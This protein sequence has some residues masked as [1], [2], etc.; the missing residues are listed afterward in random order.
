MVRF[1]EIPRSARVANAIGFAL[2]FGA[3]GCSTRTQIADS[4]R[5]ADSSSMSKSAV[6]EPAAAAAQTRNR[7]CGDRLITAQGIG[8]LKLG[9]IVD[10]VKRVCQVAYDTVRPGIEGDSER[11]VKVEFAP[12]EVEA[13]ILQDTVWRLNVRAPEF[14]TR[15]SVGVGSPVSA[16]LRRGDAQG[17]IGEGIFVLLYRNS[18]GM[19]FV[20]SGGIPPGRPRVWSAKEL[21]T[22]PRTTSVERIMVYRCAPAARTLTR[23]AD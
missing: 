5:V 19:S 17:M 1:A 4:S 14:R 7:G 8:R 6:V 11:V 16:L 12:G 3:V 13:E 21:R 10:S 22:L 20:L 23:P 15:D 9:I 2:W 18:C